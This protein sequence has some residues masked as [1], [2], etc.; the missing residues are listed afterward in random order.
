[1]ARRWPVR[2]L[3]SSALTDC[4]RARASS[5]HYSLVRPQNSTTVVSFHSVF[6]GQSLCVQDRAV[7]VELFALKQC[8]LFGSNLG[9]LPFKNMMNVLF[10]KSDYMTYENKRFHFISSQL[11][12]VC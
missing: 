4:L 10:N 3:Y 8:W 1:M 6:S 12:N 9:H 2:V 5:N 7:I 11:V